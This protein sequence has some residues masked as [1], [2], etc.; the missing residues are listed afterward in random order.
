MKK[1]KLH[2]LHFL[3]TDS[4]KELFFFFFFFFFGGGGGVNYI[5]NSKI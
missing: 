3:I 2:R 1:K 4:N 5:I